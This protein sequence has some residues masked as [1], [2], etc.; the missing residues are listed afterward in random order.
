LARL[1]EFC[2][3]DPKCQAISPDLEAMTLEALDRLQAGPLQ[4]ELSDPADPEQTLVI[5]VG[6]D[7][8]TEQ[9]RL[10]LYYGYTS[11]SLPWAMHR[12]QTAEDWKPMLTLAVL[13]ERAFRTVL[14]HGLVLTVQCSEFMD[15]DVEDA[16]ARGEGTLVGNYRLEQQLQGCAAW[17]HENLPKFGV[18]EPR[19]L[20]IPALLISGA[21]DPVTPPEYADEVMTLFPDSYHLVL[22]EGQHG[23]FELENS[24]QC[25][26]QIW[27]DFL[28]AGSV[29]GLDVECAE[30]MHRPAF[31]VDEQGFET[32]GVEVLLPWSSCADLRETVKLPTDGSSLFGDPS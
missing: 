1:A 2:L 26:H 17:P 24:W 23:P 21:L 19:S 8:L 12:I 14:A 5:D 25:V 29:E 16:L 15:F 31:I 7:W 22:E 9:L 32:Y 6:A 18:E 10:I 3:A 11:R 28:T 13:I 27:A 20:P 4:V 30:S